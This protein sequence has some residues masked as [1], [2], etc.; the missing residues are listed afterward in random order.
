MPG[1]NSWASASNTALARAEVSS[2]D[3]FGGGEPAGS[4]YRLWWISRTAAVRVALLVP[5]SVWE[6]TVIPRF[7]HEVRQAAAQL[8]TTL[9]GAPLDSPIQETEY[10]RVF[11]AMAQE[12][13]DAL[14]VG[15][16]VENFTHRRLIIE[17]A[18]RARLPVMY[19]WRDHVVLGGL[20]AYAIDLL[21]V[22]RRIAGQID[23][24]LKG[25]NPGDIPFHQPTTFKLII[26]VK[27]ARTL[28]LEMPPSLL[29][30][31]DEVIE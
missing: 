12:R 24:I 4:R 21:D 27:T 26:N 1:S 23:Q 10:R 7:A 6:G 5:R 20:M 17:L 9:L 3:G 13:V 29:A 30:R 28:G 19:P 14:L 16:S 22:Y 18:E 15:E 31:A 25:A 11:A 8:G 2:S